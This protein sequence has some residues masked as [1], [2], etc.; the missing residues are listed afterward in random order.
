MDIYFHFKK[1]I[2]IQINSFF[3]KIESIYIIYIYIYID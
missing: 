1:S 2:F 3:E